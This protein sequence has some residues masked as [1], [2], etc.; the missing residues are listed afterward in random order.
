VEFISI[1]AYSSFALFFVGGVLSLINVFTGLDYPA[2]QTKAGFYSFFSLFNVSG[3]IKI[4]KD[5]GLCRETIPLV[6][7]NLGGIGFIITFC[8][9][10]FTL[11]V[12]IF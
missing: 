9:V 3:N 7:F 1:V 12:E 4:F 11:L 8:I 6:L 5:R 2:R 10:I